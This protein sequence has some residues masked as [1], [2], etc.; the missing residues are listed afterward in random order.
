MS[1]RF[2]SLRMALRAFEL[3]RVWRNQDQR[4]HFRGAMRDRME[5]T[6]RAAE[7]LHRRY[8]RSAEYRDSCRMF[9]WSR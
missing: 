2:D 5:R 9:G 7:Y 6:E 3:S 4:F 1:R 8:L